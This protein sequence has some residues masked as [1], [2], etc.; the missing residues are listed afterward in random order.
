[1]LSPI[2]RY[3]GFVEQTLSKRLTIAETASISTETETHL[4]ELAEEYMTQEIS[5]EQAEQMAVEQFGSP[6]EF[7]CDMLN[8][9]L[10]P[11]GHKAWSYIKYISLAVLLV[12]IIYADV[13]PT[14]A[15]L[16]FLLPFALFVVSVVMCKKIS[17]PRSLIAAIPASLLALFFALTVKPINKNTSQS[18]WTLVSKSGHADVVGRSCQLISQSIDTF[19]L[20]SNFNQ[21]MYGSHK[22]KGK[23]ADTYFFIPRAKRNFQSDFTLGK[24]KYFAPPSI[25]SFE[26]YLSQG[27]SSSN[28]TPHLPPRG[29]LVG[30]HVAK[31]EW[32]KALPQ[33][34]QSV[35]KYMVWTHDSYNP[36]Y[37][38]ETLEIQILGQGSWVLLIFVAAAIAFDL[39]ITQIAQYA[40]N[41]KLLRILFN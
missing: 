17:V 10:S 14:L 34:A 1:M 30:Y 26:S 32:M 13:A 41:Q 24:R 37:V 40:S 23:T 3:V 27:F 9:K 11:H 19:H 12:E 20:K 29:P 36:D 16:F 38:Q 5:A 8:R 39:A 31:N 35:R 18:F 21:K 4:R 25:S 2:T 22:H 15:F 6:F 33:M 7:V 28:A